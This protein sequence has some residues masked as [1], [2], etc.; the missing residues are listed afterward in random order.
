[1]LTIGVIGDFDAAFRSHVATNEAL[2]H[3]AASACEALEVAWLPTPSLETA[4]G[5]HALDACD[6]LWV[7][8]GSPYRSFEGALEAIRFARERDWPLVAT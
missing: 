2:H 7:S 3:A 5:R 4:A 1:M 6:G 8:P